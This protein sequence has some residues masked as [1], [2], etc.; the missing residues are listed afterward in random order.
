MPPSESTVH[1]NDVQMSLSG[2]LSQ[3]FI[4]QCTLSQKIFRLGI[5]DNCD[6]LPAAPAK[7]RQLLLVVLVHAIVPSIARVHFVGL[8]P[9]IKFDPFNMKS[10][11]VNNSEPVMLR[12]ILNL[13]DRQERVVTCRMCI[14]AKLLQGLHKFGLISEEDILPYR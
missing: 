14:L 3:K 1:F 8:I 4:L 10:K 11:N 7:K 6:S 5:S 13:V 12:K 2:F 9:Y